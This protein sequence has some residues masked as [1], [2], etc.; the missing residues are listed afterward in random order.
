M[1]FVGIACWFWLVGVCDG[2]TM[3]LDTGEGTFA[4]DGTGGVGGCIEPGLTGV[5]EED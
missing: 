2:E 5:D 4:N 1:L 3:G